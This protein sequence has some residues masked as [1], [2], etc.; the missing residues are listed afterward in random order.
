[1]KT[2][3]GT[4]KK[5]QR[6]QLLKNQ[7]KKN[8]FPKAIWLRYLWVIFD[9]STVYP[10]PFQD[11]ED[12]KKGD[13]M[14]AKVEDWCKNHLD[15]EEMNRTQTI[16]AHVWRGLAELGL[17]AI[18]I[19]IKY[20]GLGMSQTNYMRILSTVA[21]YCGSTAATLSAHQSIGAPQPLKLMGN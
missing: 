11:R 1:M 12:K 19:P 17:F 18:K 8:G 14:C 20:N 10:Y 9:L 5:L 21:R 16:P 2:K 7:E 3:I 15:G 6:L 13:D 4:K